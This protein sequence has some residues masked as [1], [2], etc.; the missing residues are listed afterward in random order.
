MHSVATCSISGFMLGKRVFP[1]AFSLGSGVISPAAGRRK[2]MKPENETPFDESALVA[3]AGKGDPSAFKEIY[4]RYKNSIAASIYKITGNRHDTEELL[5]DTFVTAF[6]KLNRFRGD[7]SFEGWLRRI[8]VN[9]ALGM[10]RKYRKLSIVDPDIIASNRESQPSSASGNPARSAEYSEFETDFRQ[11]VARLD[12][13]MREAFCLAVLDKKP[14]S[15]IADLLGISL[16][17]V[18]VRVYRARKQLQCELEKHISN[19]RGDRQ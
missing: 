14:Y 12:E 9:S 11:A 4:E 19:L 1:V 3:R 15:D 5:Q 17:L 8:A 2:V 7:G 13:E 16:S 10:I 6:R 18:K